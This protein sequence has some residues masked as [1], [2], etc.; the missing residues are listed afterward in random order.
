MSIKHITKINDTEK[1]F[2]SMESDS[3]SHKFEFDCVYC[4]KEFGDDVI[5][6]AKHIGKEHD[7]VRSN[8]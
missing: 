4:G 6:L 5:E 1:Y 2:H 7:P 3:Q 8:N